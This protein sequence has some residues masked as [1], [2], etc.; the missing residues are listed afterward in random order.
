MGSLARKLRKHAKAPT[1][2]APTIVD[3]VAALPPRSVFKGRSIRATTLTRALAP[4]PWDFSIVKPGDEGVPNEPS[5]EGAELGAR[6]AAMCDEQ[7]AH[8][9]DQFPNRMPRCIDCAARLG[10]LPNQCLPTLGDLLK[11]AG[12]SIPFYCHKGL[13][14]DEDQPKRLCTGFALLSSRMLRVAQLKA[15]LAT[16]Q[17]E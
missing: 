15:N 10:T 16:E 3:Q 7:E 5:P 13:K 17:A 4:A 11:C 14:S 1:A 8:D 6:V 9:A 12:E 2:L